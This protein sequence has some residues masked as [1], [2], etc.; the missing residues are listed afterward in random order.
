[1]SRKMRHLVIATLALFNPGSVP[2]VSN[3]QQYALR[4]T[5]ESKDYDKVIASRFSLV[6][7]AISLR[8]ALK[9]MIRT[10]PA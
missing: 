2:Q 5:I 7:R 9:P 1:M 8:V 4:L 3:T 6:K 10:G